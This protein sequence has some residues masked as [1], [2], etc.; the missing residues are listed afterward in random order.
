VDQFNVDLSN[1]QPLASTNAVC[2]GSCGIGAETIVD[3]VVAADDM[4]AV[5]VTSMGNVYSA[6]LTGQQTATHVGAVPGAPQRIARDSSY[7]Y[8]TTVNGAGGSVVALPIAGGG[9]V[10]VA[11]N[12][13]PPFGIA[14][15]SNIVYWTSADGIVRATGALLP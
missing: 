14:I 15:Y 3:I 8:V 5:W 7:A 13:S 10:T 4:T 2:N 12:P 11:V 9:P 6:L 1:M